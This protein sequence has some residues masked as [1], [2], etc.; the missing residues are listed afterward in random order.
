M[1][2]S[3]AEGPGAAS[4]HEDERQE[5]QRSVS[6]APHGPVVRSS[7]P[8]AVAGAGEHAT[9]VFDT[10]LDRFAKAVESHDLQLELDLL[11][12]EDSY[13]RD[14]LALQWGYRTFDRSQIATDAA[15]LAD[16]VGLRGVRPAPDRTPPR[17]V[18]RSGRNV[19][20]G[21]FDFDVDAGT[22]T[23]FARVLV[24][25]GGGPPRT[26]LLLTTL[27]HLST[28]PDTRHDHE[29][30]EFG[31]SNWLDRRNH[32][33]ELG[34]GDPEVIIVGAGQ[35]GLALAARLRQMGVR[36]LVI[37]RTAR[38]GDVWRHRY[39]SLTLHNETWANTLPYL[40]F[41]KTWP[42][43]LPKDK[44]AG[45]LEYYAE[46]MELNVWTGT[47]V[48][49]AV[50]DEQA[51]EWKVTLERNGQQRDVRA[52]HLV[53]AT[54][55]VSGVPLMPRLPGADSFAGTLIHSSQFD[56]GEA[57]KGKHAVVFGTGNS[58]HDV[59]QDLHAAGAASVTMVQR[60][61]TC[62]VSLEPSGTMVY[63]LYSEHDAVE[64]IDL[65]T[66]AIPY[67]VMRDS[68]QWLTR[69]TCRLDKDLLDGLESAGFRT[70]FE[71]DG[72]G[73]HMKYLRRGGGY[74]INVGC[75]DLII[76]GEVQLLAAE[77]IAGLNHDGLELADGE[78]HQ[79]DLV[80]MA[81][82]FENQQSGVR[83][84]L[85]DE[86]ADRVGQIWGFD[87][88]F[89]LRNMWRRTD[90]AG[91][92]VMGGNLLESRLHSRFLALQIKAELDGLV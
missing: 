90:Q 92:W 24:E 4:V 52:P 75:S 11:F 79:A 88:D 30:Y 54:G 28:Q 58:G 37:E 19:V 89:E 27:Q 5:A 1:T 67:E 64:D 42:T 59:A 16:S 83:R 43:F 22:G 14:I 56:S 78:T 45:W 77:Q 62:V 70:D 57:Y 74:Y 85:G 61:P 26:W 76:S 6:A 50:R 18:R 80:V 9:S 32:E 17:L 55:T 63:A 91:F 33:L 48:L 53:M 3:L 65:I 39:H 10:W 7:K 68:Y 49:G 34:D 38:V 15:R 46:A 44:L 36:A 84:L 71:E 20:E 66:T 69:K 47:T 23:G 51:G 2:E 13:W 60:S 82:G 35:S 25:E 41:P 73:F 87:D 81:T 29:S 40:P 12:G 31:A 21:Y 86:V 8:D 72:T